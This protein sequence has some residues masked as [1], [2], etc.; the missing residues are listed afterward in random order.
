MRLFAYRLAKEL[1]VWDVEGMLADMTA[2]QFRGWLDYFGVEPF[3]EDRRDFGTAMIA[4][5]MASCWS[6]RV[7][8][9]W[10]FMPLV[11]K[12]ELTAEQQRARLQHS[13]AHVR[14][15]LNA[16]SKKQDNG[17]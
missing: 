17:R 16:M 5:T 7:P 4:H 2:A 11:R 12:P 6:K 8:D 10:R 3:G 15:F 14:A 13:K 9:I 1:G